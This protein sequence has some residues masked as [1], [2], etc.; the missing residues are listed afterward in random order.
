[1][2]ARRLDLPAERAISP[3][4]IDLLRLIAH[5]Q[6]PFVQIKDRLRYSALPLNP[7]GKLCSRTARG[8]ALCYLLRLPEPFRFCQP[9]C[10]SLVFRLSYSIR[11][12]SS[13]QVFIRAVIHSPHSLLRYSIK[14]VC[15]LQLASDGG[16]RD[17]VAATIDFQVIPN[18]A[19][20][21]LAASSYR[22]H[23]AVAGRL[24]SLSQTIDVLCKFA[25]TGNQFY[26]RDSNF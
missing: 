21:Q 20:V 10:H 8:R 16:P 26:I 5:R 1:L 12:L 2:L 3:T 7:A 9:R 23:A 6:K 11:A 18:F 4:F 19:F 24:V 13:W 22:S 25:F 17:Q 14:A 15:V